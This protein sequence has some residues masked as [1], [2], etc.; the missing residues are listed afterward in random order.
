MSVDT[1]NTQLCKRWSSFYSPR[2]GV[3]PPTKLQRTS[4]STNTNTKMPSTLHRSE[5]MVFLPSAP[6]SE[7]SSSSSDMTTQQYL[8]MQHYKDQRLKR[9]SLLSAAGMGT[10]VP[11]IT[12]PSHTQS[13]PSVR[14]T[15]S[16]ALLLTIPSAPSPRRYSPSS[17]THPKPPVQI[18]LPSTSCPITQHLTCRLTSPLSPMPRQSV[19]ILLPSILSRSSSKHP[20]LKY[21]SS[22]GSLY[23]TALVN[24]ALSSLE[25]QQIL[26]MKPMF[27]L[28]IMNATRELE[29]IVVGQQ[30][31]E[32]EVER[33]DGMCC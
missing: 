22:S 8:V 3:P 33:V 31:R 25:V 20:I 21:H 5:S 17:S 26:H 16:S 10:P 18:I 13:Q 27:P 24:H 12:A 15:S 23:C 11:I 32:A 28:S 19:D 4:S 2:T 30:E 1:N 14:H 7:A 29:I 9:K 6:F